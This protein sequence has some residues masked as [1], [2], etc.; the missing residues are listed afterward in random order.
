[1]VKQS[2]YPL[3]EFT[4]I[5]GKKTQAVL[6]E[7]QATKLTKGFAT[8]LLTP[9][10]KFVIGGKLFRGSLCLIVAREL[11]R[12]KIPSTAAWSA[13]VALELAGSAILVQDDVMD[14]AELRRG[15]PALQHQYAQSLVTRQTQLPTE[16]VKSYG[17]SLS[18]C[19]S[20]ELFFL[21]TQLLA[22]AECE[23][24]MKVALLKTMSEEIVQ[25][26]S[27]QAEEL[28]FAN[29]PLGDPNIT[30]EKII[31]IMVGKT[32]RYTAVWPL[33]VA[34]I[35]AKVSGEVLQALIEYGEAMGI[36]FQLSDDRLGLFGNPQQTGKD[37]DSD[38][39]TGKKTLYA[40]LAIE[41]LTGKSWQFFKQYYGNPRCTQSEI[42]QLQQLLTEE[43]V[44]AE[45]EQITTQYMAKAERALQQLTSYPQLQK[46]LLTLVQFLHTREH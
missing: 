1:M 2:T 43:G 45:V 39:K 25:L 28:Y 31:Q 35:L 36:V 3:G 16:Q 12:Q 20:D 13:A 29:L 30:Q 44:V 18:I 23:V 15:L 26:A 5:L 42:T 8:D 19:A 17:E 22:T 10:E 46:I 4:L 34:A 21:A 24:E 33:K 40:F 38:V 32:A 11:S 6:K 41:R 27:F 14:Q 9:A 7:F 37:A